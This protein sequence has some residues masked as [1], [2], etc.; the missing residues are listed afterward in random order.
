MGQGA[1]C[2]VDRDQPVKQPDSD[3]PAAY[4]GE[5]QGRLA[6]CQRPFH[7]KFAKLPKKQTIKVNE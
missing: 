6:D 7:P 1:F 2:G 3:T 4:G 5:A